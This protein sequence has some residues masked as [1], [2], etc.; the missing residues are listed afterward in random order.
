MLVILAC[1]MISGNSLTEQEADAAVRATLDALATSDAQTAMPE[2]QVS[3]EPDVTQQIET[4]AD[5]LASTTVAEQATATQA[6]ALKETTIAGIAAQATEQ[7]ADMYAQI[8]KLYSDGLLDSKDGHFEALEDFDE[9]WAQINWYQYLNTGYSPIEYVV[10]A[11]TWWSSASDKANWNTSGCGFVFGEQD[12]E[13][14]HLVYLGLDGYVYLARILGG[15]TTILAQKRYGK[16]DIPEGE[17]DVM[18]V[19]NGTQIVY[20]VNGD[21]VVSAADRTLKGGKLNLTLLSGTNS[22][23]GTRCK[24]TAIGLWIIE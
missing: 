3:R 6:Q 15:K 11:H 19:V 4:T 1:Q 13:N 14:H 21:Q 17:A 2:K 10:Q 7:A 22:G 20:Y 8:E 24:M 18:L 12:T 9:S 5:S 23:Y 16:L